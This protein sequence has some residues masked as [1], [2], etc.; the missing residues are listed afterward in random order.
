MLY[1]FHGQAYDME[2]IMSVACVTIPNLAVFAL[3]PDPESVILYT[4]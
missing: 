3:M 4:I 2:Y 1:A